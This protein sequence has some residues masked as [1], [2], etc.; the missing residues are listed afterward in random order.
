MDLGTPLLGK[1]IHRCI[2]KCKFRPAAELSGLKV[3]G[4]TAHGMGKLHICEGIINAEK[5]MQVL[6]QHLLLQTMSLW[7]IILC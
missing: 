6:E 7:H 3:T 4:V 2:Y 1:K 5:Y